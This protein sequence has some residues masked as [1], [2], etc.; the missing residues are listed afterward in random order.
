MDPPKVG[1]KR[2]MKTKLA[3]KMEKKYLIQEEEKA[4]CYT[5]LKSR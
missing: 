5:I 1:V 2:K 3:K 4:E